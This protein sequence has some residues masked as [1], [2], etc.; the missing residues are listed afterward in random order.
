MLE[1]LLWCK[2]TSVIPSYSLA[3][4]SQIRSLIGHNNACHHFY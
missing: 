3:W 2:F 4:I 1:Y